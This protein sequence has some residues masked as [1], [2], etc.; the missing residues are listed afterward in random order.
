MHGMGK[1]RYRGQRKVLL[2]IR[3]TATLVNIKKLFTLEIPTLQ[4]L[5]CMIAPARHRPT[6]PRTPQPARP[7]TPPKTISSAA[8]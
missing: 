8:T 5:L 6:E 3:L 4:P 7:T 1:A 2:Q